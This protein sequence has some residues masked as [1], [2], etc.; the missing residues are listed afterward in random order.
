M[1]QS[2][3]N[4]YTTQ[5]EIIKKKTFE[6]SVLTIPSRIKRIESRQNAENMPLYFNFKRFDS[7]IKTYALQTTNVWNVKLEDDERI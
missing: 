5:S 2:F 4:A 6:R 1:R 7:K 3:Q